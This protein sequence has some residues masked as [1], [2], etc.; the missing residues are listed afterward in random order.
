MLAAESVTDGITVGLVLL[1][2]GAIFES[3]RRVLSEVRALRIDL[4]T[5][6]GNEE[7][8]RAEEATEREHRQGQLDVR[9]AS[10]EHRLD[11]GAG[12]FD[13]LEDQMAG[14]HAEI[15]RAIQAIGAGNPEW[16]RT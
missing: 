11:D 2:G 12:R 1:V 8:L 14:M 7:T 16:R 13:R 10:I 4:V 5:H 15:A 3:V 6:M 9:L